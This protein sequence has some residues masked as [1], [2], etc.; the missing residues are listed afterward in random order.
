MVQEVVL[1]PRRADHNHPM[2]RGVDSG[3][4]EQLVGEARELGADHRTARDDPVGKARWPKC[5]RE[6]H[7]PKDLALPEK[8]TS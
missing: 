2:R 8:G 4:E 5:G 3:E 6:L 1:H 7:Q